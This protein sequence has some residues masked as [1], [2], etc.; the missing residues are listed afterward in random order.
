MALHSSR[1]KKNVENENGLRR[2]GILQSVLCGDWRHDPRK[3]PLQWVRVGRRDQ[4]RGEAARAKYG[5]VNDDIGSVEHCVAHS[6]LYGF[7]GE[8]GFCSKHIDVQIHR[9]DSGENPVKVVNV[10]P[11]D[12][13][14]Q[15]LVPG[16]GAYPLHRRYQSAAHKAP[17]ADHADVQ[18]RADAPHLRRHLV[19]EQLLQAD[20]GEDVGEADHHVL[21]RQ[22]PDLHREG[23]FGGIQPPVLRRD[24]DPP[25]LHQPSDGHPGGADE[26]ADADPLEDGD[27]GGEAGEFPGGGEEDPVV[28]GDGEEDGEGGDDLEGGG[29]EVEGGEGSGES[30]A[31]LGEVGAELG[32]AGGEGEAAQPD[33]EEA[34]EELHLLHL[35]HG[36]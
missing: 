9:A 15:P 1:T 17:H 28:D 21:R 29:R 11:V 19:V 18:R 4:R 14:H 12:V 34:E 32:N 27:A 10:G 2:M 35:C 30:G 31:L 33:G 20:H 5:S 13:I 22:P 26:E 8:E 36:A 6:N 23:G 3:K 25:G 7:G 16:S 24:A